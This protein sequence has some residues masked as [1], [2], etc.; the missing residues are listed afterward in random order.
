MKKL[1]L[2]ILIST[3]IVGTSFAVPLID[4]KAGAGYVNLSPSGWV[5]YKGT[6]VDVKDDLHWGNSGNINAYIQLGLPVL[7]NIKVEYLPTKYDGTGKVSKT[8]TFGGIGFTATDNVYSKLDLKQYY[9]SLFYNLPVPIITPR[10]GLTVD[11]LDGNTYVKSLTTNIEREA[12][13]KAPIPMVYLGVNAGLPGIPVEVDVEAKGIAYQ[14][15]S[16]IDIKA[17][18][19]FKIV[20]I[21]MV[22]S[23]YIGAGY[24]YQ[25]LKLDDIDGLY[26]DIKFK[27][28]FGEV[29]VEF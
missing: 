15:N 21:P 2:S 13:F 9:I 24:R 29:G 8:F 11:Y 22:G 18:G 7:P 1:S 19:M 27:G 23:L 5:K 4:L 28:L 20:G 10:I 16:L 12:S 3:G 26:S 14:G 6:E 25:R 17:I